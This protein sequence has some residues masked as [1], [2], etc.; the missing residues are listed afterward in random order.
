MTWDTADPCATSP[1]FLK[2]PKY[3]SFTTPTQ[4]PTPKSDRKRPLSTQ[5]I[6]DEIASHVDHPAPN[7]SLSLPP[8]D[9]SRQLS[10]SPNPSSSSNK[11]GC[12][13]SS[14]EA[15][16]PLKIG[17][18]QETGTSIRSAGS[19]Q[20]PPP[21][22]TSASR[23]KAQQSQAAKFSMQPASSS[24]RM[25]TPTL[26]NSKKAET[27]ASHIE[28]S[29]L[30]LPTL[31]F[32]PEGF[33]LPTSG[34]ATAPAYP[35]HKLFWDPDQN[36]DGMSI[37]FPADD[38]FT[39]G[40][41]TDKGLGSFISSGTK[42]AVSQL[43]LS[44][45]FH[46][47]G[48][49]NVRQT[50]EPMPSTLDP[51]NQAEFFP[52]GLMIQG[53]SKGVDPSL[54]F[55]SPG[56]SS[57]Q[58][59]LA[60][61]A[62]NE[63]L[64]PYA[65][66]IRDA[67]IEREL[68]LERKAKRRRKV[69]DDSPAVKAALQVLRDENDICAEIKRTAT[70]DLGPQLRAGR[71]MAGRVIFKSREVIKRDGSGK[72]IRSLKHHPRNVQESQN[73]TAVTLTIDENG[74]AKTETKTLPNHP[75]MSSEGNIDDVDGVSEESESASSTESEEMTISQPQSFAFTNV[76][77]R[78]SKPSRYAAD[79]KAHSQKSSYASTFVTSDTTFSLPVSEK[80]I[81]RKLTNPL[82]DA[83]RRRS[84]HVNRRSHRALS[85]TTISDDM[86][87]V[88]YNER[89]TES[90]DETE[91]ATTSDD[92]KG[93]AQSELKKIIRNRSQHGA[94]NR[95]TARKSSYGPHHAYASF[96]G[97]PPPSIYSKSVS[98]SQERA[99]EI[100]DDI[101]P[102]T[103][104][105]PDLATPSTSNESHASDSTRCVCHMSAE[106]EGE[107]MILW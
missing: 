43:P 23:R 88:V 104:T 83:H 96:D 37:D 29:P 77:P 2:T 103:I 100:I 45:S 91:T 93:D 53:T 97:Q 12:H 4:S 59:A 16:T 82:A 85:P 84:T 39:F 66:Q 33:G 9:P 54:L 98:Y 92:D 24:R 6:E 60:S 26:A 95:S 68:S 41:G 14:K 58:P 70:D 7:P 17:L 51:T 67:Q 31:Q 105:D 34:P 20:T 102:T 94:A 42:A 86:S 69:Q 61:L 36:T 56:H 25:S 30:Q 87:D 90:Q 72:R 44:P 13:H 38:P 32:S 63:T 79:A 40:E 50:D 101:S 80:S 3:L 35:Q 49:S 99:Q 18:G 75:G 28:E 76:K 62:V 73:R 52:T 48:T 15:S 89:G 65:N 64:Q 47:F 1:E 81:R 5:T 8:V 71:S 11:N 57:G 78:R 107:L 55:S 27:M 10:S 106:I 19:M 22:S 46:D 74:R 21:T